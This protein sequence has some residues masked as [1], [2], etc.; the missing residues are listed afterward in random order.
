MA[1][2]YQLKARPKN[3]CKKVD[4][5]STNYFIRFKWHEKRYEKWKK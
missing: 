2:V 1:Y 5:Y 3:I 4:A